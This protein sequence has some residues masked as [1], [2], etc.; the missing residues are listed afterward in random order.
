MSQTRQKGLGRGFDALMPQGVQSIITEQIDGRVQDLFIKDIYPNSDQPRK[1]FDEA[2]INELANSIKQFGVLQPLIVSDSKN[3]R[4]T[5][6]AG[7]RRWRASGIAGLDKVPA[8]IRTSEEL[9]QLEISIVENIQRV[10]L[11]P[12]EQAA[13]IGKLHEMFGISYE[14]IAK[15]LNKAEST[16]NNIVRLLQLPEDARDALRDK[17]ITEGHARSILALKNFPEQQQKLLTFIQKNGWSVRQAEQ[18]VVAVKAGHNN[19][20]KAQSKT[21]KTTPE[22]EKLSKILQYPVS[23]SNMAK[24]GRLVIRF[25]SED[26]FEKLIGLLSKLDEQ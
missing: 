21:K 25:K 8:I 9:E 22:T 12:L 5:I 11:S 20:D 6:I 17:K 3:G 19:S 14:K 15:R 18:F 7:E 23:V 4:Y 13:S 16:V 26:D 10:D 2:L 1:E 24:G